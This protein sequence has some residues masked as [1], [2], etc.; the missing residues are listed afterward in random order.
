MVLARALGVLSLVAA[1]TAL[2]QEPKSSPSPVPAPT[3]TPSVGDAAATPSPTPTPVPLIEEPPLAPGELKIRANRQE[4]GEGKLHYEGFVDLRFGQL[5]IQADRLDMI[6]ET[7]PDGASAQRIEASG[8]VVFMSGTERISGETL[9]LDLDTGKGLFTKASGYLQPDVLFEAESIERVDADTYRLKGAKFT[10]CTQPNPR[11]MFKAHSATVEIDKKIKATLVGLSIKGVPTP[12]LI[13][14][15]QFPISPDQ[16]AT[17]ILTPRYGSSTFKGR[18]IGAGFFWAMG[19]SM[20]Q[21][22]YYDWFTEYGIGFGHE[23][24]YIR[25]IGSRGT[26]RSYFTRPTGAP[27]FAYDLD[28]SASRALPHRF[29]ATLSANFYSDLASRQNLQ[30]SLDYSST[31]TRRGAVGLQGSLGPAFVRLVAD[32]SDFFFFDDSIQRRRHLPQIQVSQS[33]KKIG[34]TGIAFGYQASAERLAQGNAGSGESPVLQQYSRLDVAPELTR[35]ISVPFLQLTPKALVRYTRYGSSLD[36]NLELNG[37]PLDRQFF[38]GSMDVRGP[39]LFKVF[40]LPGDVYS[41]KFKHTFE[42]EFLYTYRSKVLVFNSLPSFDFGDQYTG[43]NQLLYGVTNRIYAKRMGPAGKLETHELFTWRLSQTYYV[44]IGQNQ[45]QFDPNYYSATFARG[46]GGAPS[47]KSPIQSSLSIRPTLR[48]S[49]IYSTEYNPNFKQ[50][51]SSSVNMYINQPR[52]AL[53][54]GWARGVNLTEVAENRTTLYNTF[55]GSGKIVVWPERLTVEGSLTYDALQKT[56]LQSTARIRYGIQCCGFAVERVNFD[57]RYRQESK[58]TF[59]IELA[60]I[61]S[62]GNFLG[63]NPANHS[64]AGRK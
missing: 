12:I 24:R 62:V 63:D 46:P 49:V 11:W 50:F 15:F 33:P 59:Q 52:L 2:A 18:E 7:K 4:G 13:P 57:T 38:E 64:N 32:T 44:D 61:G 48:S 47:H 10:A 22:F 14:Y 31:R 6:D 60:G 26:F 27:S 28:W 8:N 1:T 39:K 54:A 53:Q 58:T 43:T 56:I 17:G 9:R 45:G 19:R 37:P 20:D 25:D 21:T 42:P 23:F 41:E 55:R 5:R 51:T 34:R 40:R 36:E 29:K 35:T 30:D 3:A 16:R